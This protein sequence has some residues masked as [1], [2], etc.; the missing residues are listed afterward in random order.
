MVEQRHRQ[1]NDAYRTKIL[2]SEWCSR[3]KIRLIECNDKCR[4]LKNCPV[5]GLCGRC[6]ITTPQLHTVYVYTVYFF[7]LGRGGGLELT[8]ENVRGAI[9]HKA[10]RKYQHD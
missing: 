8:R 4:Y 10:G 7:T 2:V 3:R 6:F 9:V 1:L 5:K